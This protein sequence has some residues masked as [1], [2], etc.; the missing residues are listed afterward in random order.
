MENS[1]DEDVS[2]LNCNKFKL[3]LIKNGFSSKDAQAFKGNTTVTAI[4]MKLM[5]LSHS[6]GY[7]STLICDT[8]KTSNCQNKILYR[9]IFLLSVSIACSL[10]TNTH[11]RTRTHTHT[12]FL[13]M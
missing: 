3:W 12:L 4:M 9:D 6:Q 8:F 7:V 11:T 5:H 13:E 10:H 2:Q 1:D